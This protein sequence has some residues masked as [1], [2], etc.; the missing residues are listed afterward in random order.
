MSSDLLCC[1]GTCPSGWDVYNYQSTSTITECTSA[2]PW[3]PLDAANVCSACPAPQCSPGTWSSTGLASASGGCI[4]CPAGSFGSSAGNTADTCDGLCRIGS[5]GSSAGNTAD[6]CDGDCTVLAGSYCP[7]GSEYESDCP[8]GSFCAMPSTTEACPISTG[9]LGGATSSDSCTDCDEDTEVQICVSVV[10]TF[11]ALQS[12]VGSVP[13][14]GV[15]Y[16]IDVNADMS[17]ESCQLISYCGTEITITSG[18]NIGIRGVA[19]N[20]WVMDAAA[21]NSDRRQHI[22]IERGASLVVKNLEFTRGYYASILN[23]KTYPLFN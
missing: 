9:N 13:N 19:G 3:T 15:L 18:K 11:T 4:A 8:G 7:A 12:A 20:R 21:S 23:P 5:F 16:V 17:W 10:N 22:S 2:T 14:N 1:S 6:T